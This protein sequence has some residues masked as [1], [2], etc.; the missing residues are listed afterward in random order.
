[1]NHAIVNPPI[2][3]RKPTEEVK[4]VYVH[5]TRETDADIFVSGA[6]VVATSATLTHYNFMGQ[7]SKTATED[8]SML[9]TFIVPIDA[10]GLKLFCRTNYKLAAK[11]NGSPFDYPL[12]SRFDENDAI[13]GL[14]NVFIPWE[15][16][17]IYR[18]P[19]R[20]MSFFSGS[21]FLNGF[22][23]QGC[24]RFAVK[25]AFIKGLLAKALHATGSDDSR[26]NQA[27]L[28]EVVA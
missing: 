10:P 7:T 12:S 26:G 19:A 2:D 3:R 22:L 27:L 25:L 15:D 24:T 1:M 21:G 9:L 20:I 8:L 5:V 23:F 17:L 16:V 13:F 28:G 6:K 18:D 4:D 11:T 14:D